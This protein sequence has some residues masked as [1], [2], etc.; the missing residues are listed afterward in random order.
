MTGCSLLL[1]AVADIMIQRTFLTSHVISIDW[2]CDSLAMTRWAD[3]RWHIHWL[4]F[5]EY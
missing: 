1:D 3:T 2:V 5:G 4:G